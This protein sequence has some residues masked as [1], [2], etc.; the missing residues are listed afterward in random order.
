[1][2]IIVFS[3]RFINKIVTDI[4]YLVGLSDRADSFPNQLS[5]VEQ[6]RVCIARALINRPMYLI[7]D[8]PRGN[9]DPNTSEDIMKL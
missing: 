3:K 4:L 5:G 7:A 2:K 9:L 6:Q 1:L 8:E